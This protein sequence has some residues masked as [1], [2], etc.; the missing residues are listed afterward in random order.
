METANLT[1]FL[2]DLPYGLGDVVG[3][4]CMPAKKG[5]D[6]INKFKKVFKKKKSITRR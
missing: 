1:I 6:I 2:D 5:F 3:D 4:K